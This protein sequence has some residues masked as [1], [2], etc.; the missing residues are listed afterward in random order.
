MFTKQNGRLI[1]Y[2]K[3][4]VF[5]SLKRGWTAFHHTIHR[6]TKCVVVI[7]NKLKM[8]LNPYVKQLHY[9]YMTHRLLYTNLYPIPLKFFGFFKR[10]GL[11]RPVHIRTGR[12]TEGNLE[13]LCYKNASHL[14][15]SLPSLE[16]AC[17]LH[18]NFPLFYPEDMGSIFYEI[19]LTFWAAR[20]HN[21]EDINSIVTVLRIPNSAAF[22]FRQVIPYT[23]QMSQICKHN[24]CTSVG[25]LDCY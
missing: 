5:V 17:Y 22:Q 13:Y 21:L 2:V 3:G 7:I 23:N 25:L 9:I 11:E 15:T 18:L 6:T 14:A 10:F 12:D 19:F 4:I 8:K 20:C 1:I 16:S 24:F